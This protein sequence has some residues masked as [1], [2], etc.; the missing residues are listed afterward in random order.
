MASL[1]ELFVE[2][3]V[4]ADTKELEQFKKKLEKVKDTMDKTKSKNDN[5]TKSLKTLGKGLA[6]VATAITTAI[7]ALNKLSDSLIAS[8]QEFLNLTRNSDIALG[9]FQK[10][11]NIGRM[12]GVRNA[13]QQLAGLNQRLFELKLTGQGA[14]GFILA[15][16][17]PLGASAEGVMEQLRNRVAGLDDTSA[18]FL[19]TRMGLDP[20]MLHLLRMSR[21]EFEKL[22]ETVR[23]YQ[24][25]EKQRAQI[26]VLNKQLEIARIKLEYIKDRV[27]LKL[28]PYLVKLT[29]SLANISEFL[30]KSKVAA[31]ALAVVITTA[32]MPAFLKLFKFLLM[33]P[34]V[35]ALTALFGAIYLILDDIAGYSQGKDSL[36]GHL[37]NTMEDFRKNGFFSD[38]VPIWIQ[39]LAKITDDLMKIKNE[40]I[41]KYSWDNFTFRGNFKPIPG[42][43]LFG[44]QLLA[45]IARTGF[46]NI[47]NMSGALPPTNGINQTLD[48]SYNVNKN[49]DMNVEMNNTFYTQQP[50]QN[51]YND[52]FY[53]RNAF[54]PF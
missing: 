19:L 41:F 7:Y 30:M 21:E 33:N 9:T 38:D 46:D 35:A 27:I 54:S 32:L 51:I 50:A 37:V 20:Q 28:L 5:L 34:Y 15:G 26:Q 8:N 45:A 39:V 2:L 4:F 29:T 14:E 13:A 16:I 3:G 36:W 10:W 23:K 48:N 22:S 12:F 11:N 42:T 44:L 40:G 25:T 24:L 43:P 53:L 31:A 47:K 1:G 18:T 49:Q 52:L 17:N 6:G